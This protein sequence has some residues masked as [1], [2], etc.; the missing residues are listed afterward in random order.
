MK[1]KLSGTITHRG[2]CEWNL[3]FA[4]I[5][6]S[7]TPLGTFMTYHF[8]VKHQIALPLAHVSLT[9]DFGYALG[10]GMVVTAVD[11]VTQAFGLFSS[12]ATWR[13]EQA[14]AS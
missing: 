14:R 6:S 2:E 8:Q 10:K 4:G 13:L 9:I 7:E 11:Q 5:E 1:K 12:R 3:T